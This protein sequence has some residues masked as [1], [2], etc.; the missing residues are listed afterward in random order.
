MLAWLPVFFSASVFFMPVERMHRFEAPQGRGGG[1]RRF[2]PEAA[3]Q[4]EQEHKASMKT[5]LAT[6]FEALAA[7]LAQGKTDRLINF[8][9]CSVNMMRYTP[10]NQELV[11]SQKPDATFVAT[12]PTWER[13]YN[14]RPNQKSTIY[15]WQPKPYVV[16]TAEPEEQLEGEQEIAPT[17]GRRGEKI[18]AGTAFKPL[19]VW[20]VTQTSQIKDLPEKPLPAFFTP[21]EGL[22]GIELVNNG[23]Q[24]AME[25]EGIRVIETI[26]T[27]GAEGYNLPG[28][29]A[30]KEGLSPT[31]KALVRIHEWTHQLLHRTEEA[32]YYSKQKKEGH[33]EAVAYIVMKH[34]TGFE[35]PF[36]RDY[37][38]HYENKP[39]VLRVE[40]ETILGAAQH[41]IEAVHAQEPEGKQ[42]DK[43]PEPT[44][45]A[46]AIQEVAQG[47]LWADLN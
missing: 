45:E 30:T 17:V 23:L 35:S 37:L 28:V 6:H 24:A 8:L 34:L 19:A 46:A 12:Y 1:Y 5:A 4:N 32:R 47:D 40:M 25:A 29:V 13:E 20:D 2:S 42:L 7:E 21:S 43:T 33:A 9:T 44:P 14:R 22:E 11:Y 18:Q 31:N 15:I 16:K 38:L 41:I 36:T 39:D 10:A 27:E 3:K 26:Y